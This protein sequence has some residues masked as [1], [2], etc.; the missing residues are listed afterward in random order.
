MDVEV[1][2]EPEW[3]TLVEADGVNVTSRVADG[4][5]EEA[6]GETVGVTLL[7]VLYSCSSLCSRSRCGTIMLGLKMST[8]ISLSP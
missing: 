1:V 2:G 7:P 4:K 8:W 5:A 3:S 6:D